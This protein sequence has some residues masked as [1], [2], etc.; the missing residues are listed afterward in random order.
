M[1]YKEFFNW[2]TER[3]FDGCWGMQEAVI[4]LDI[5]EKMKHTSI[6]KRKTKWLEFE[7]VANEIVTNTNE[8]IE[9]IK[10]E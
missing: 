1:K 2:C 10:N 6:F 3:T 7:P 8:I 4:C 9:R 5:I